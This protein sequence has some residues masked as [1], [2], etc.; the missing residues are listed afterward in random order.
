MTNPL[1]RRGGGGLQHGADLQWSG[2]YGDGQSGTGKGSSG[3]TVGLNLCFWPVSRPTASP[4]ARFTFICGDENLQPRLKDLREL[5]GRNGSGFQRL[6]STGGR[7][8]P[9]VSEGRSLPLLSAGPHAHAPAVPGRRV[10]AGTLPQLEARSAGRAALSPRRPR[11]PASV[12]TA[13]TS[14]SPPSAFTVL[15]CS[16]GACESRRSSS[17]GRVTP[18]TL[19]LTRTRSSNFPKCFFLFFLF[20]ANT[21]H[22]LIG[23]F[24]NKNNWILTP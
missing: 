8:R 14:T 7:G 11:R 23:A 19:L 4:L 18:R 6:R 12:S 10:V 20:P 17:S 3:R 13:T 5:K 9:W 21:S 2:F 22:D 16:R 1:H 24:Y 15:F